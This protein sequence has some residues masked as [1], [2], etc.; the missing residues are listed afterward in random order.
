MGRNIA[1]LLGGRGYQ[2][3]TS[4]IYLGIA[5]RAL[6]PHGFG[7]FALVLAYG[8]AIANIA[9][10]QSWQ[11]VIRYGAI[12]LARSDETR[13]SRLLGFTATLD[14]ASALGGAVIAAVGVMLIGPG[15]GWSGVEQQRAALFGAALLLSIGA[16]PGGILRLL[17]RFDL[18]A[19]CQAI[20]PSVRLMRSII[21]WAVDGGLSG[22]LIVWAAGALIQSG[23]TWAVALGRAG[24]RLALGRRHFGVA[25]AE[26]A[27]IW[28]FMLVT[29]ASSS[30]GLLMEQIG[31]L[32][33]GA[34]GGATAAGGFRIAAKLAKALA[35]PA[36]AMPRVLY[37]ELARLTASGGEAALDR[38]MRL[39]GRIS[40][41]I[42]IGMILAAAI[43]GPL[44]LH[45]LAGSTYRFAHLYLVLLTVAVAIDL[46]GFALE[47]LLRARGRVGAVL[48]IRIAGALAYIPLLAG[49]LPWIGPAGA[50]I[51][52]I[53][54]SA[55][56]RLML[57]RAVKR[58]EPARG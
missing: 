1:W 47:P 13:L 38:V 2:A 41:A 54:S 31:T 7:E 32:A 22:F 30:V 36:E 26:N 10:F 51:A 21:A 9:Q 16:T 24:R 46:S 37:P 12:H 53:A 19:Y 39:T 28:R 29:N 45:L 50:A 56:M 35:K 18:I 11:S 6:K 33:V 23:A 43:A 52:T 27:G 40:L 55:A 3:V 5:A 44:M 4:L 34:I 8:Q 25:A 57:G 14:I 42:A 48:G 49:L 58:S 17:D 20:G 15:L